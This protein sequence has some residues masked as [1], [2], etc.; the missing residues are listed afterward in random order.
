MDK[1]HDDVLKEVY[2]KAVELKLDE[3]FIAILQT[4]LERRQLRVSAEKNVKKG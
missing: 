1:L 4:E 3:N 2:R